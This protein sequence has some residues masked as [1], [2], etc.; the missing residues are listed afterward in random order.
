MKISVLSRTC[1][2]RLVYGRSNFQRW[3]SMSAK[4]IAAK[5][6]VTHENIATYKGSRVLLLAGLGLALSLCAA[7][8]GQ[9]KHYASGDNAPRPLTAILF[10]QLDRMHRTSLCQESMERHTVSRTIILPNS[11]QLSL[12]AT[13]ARWRRCM[14]SGLSNSLPTIMAGMWHLL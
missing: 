5:S 11:L 8:S 4:F 9:Q 6:A 13:T 1:T 7:S 14:R 12:P 10:F 2:W 3:I